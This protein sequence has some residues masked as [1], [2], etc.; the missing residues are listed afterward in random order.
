M[1]TEVLIMRVIQYAFFIGLAGCALVVVFSWVSILRAV[2]SKD[3][4]EEK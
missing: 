1:R 4:P 2:L 3:G